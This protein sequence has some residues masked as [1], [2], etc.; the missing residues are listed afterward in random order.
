MIATQDE[1]GY[2]NTF[3]YNL[4]HG[5]MTSQV[6]D[7]DPPTDSGWSA[8]SGDRLKLTSDYLYDQTGRQTQALGPAHDI[9]GT[10]VRTAQWTVYKDLDLQTYQGQ[11]YAT[12]SGPYTYTLVNPVTV[13]IMDQAGRA[14]HSIQATRTSTM[15]RLSASD[16]FTDQTKWCRWTHSF[17]DDSGL[18]TSSRVYFDI[19]SSGDGTEGTNYDLTSYDYDP[20]DRQNKVVSPAGTITR[21]VYNARGL[22]SETFIGTDDTGATP[23]DPT[24]GGAM[25]NDMKL[26]QENQYD[27]G[28]GGGNS[29]LTRTRQPIDDDG[30]RDRL[31]HYHHDFRD[32][33]IAIEGEIDFYQRNIYDNLDRVIQVDRR[34]TTAEGAPWCAVKPSTTTGGGSIKPNAMP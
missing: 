12:G 32:R 10:T 20:M 29:N 34:N 27:R 8:N 25:G 28:V 15:G 21:T 9:D 33:Q 2:I 30:R 24:G 13:T 11:G 7:D 6:Q 16:S 31:T 19:P 5:G 3:Q 14:V 1:R 22:V 23:S 17:Y 4:G 18:L 26:V